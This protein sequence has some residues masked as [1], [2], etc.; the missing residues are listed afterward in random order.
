MALLLLAT[1]KQLVFAQ[2]TRLWLLYPFVALYLP[3]MFF[4]GLT[5]CPDLQGGLT[6]CPVM[7]TVSLSLSPF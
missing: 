3:K 4:L 5:T 1:K 6:L 7:P 2:H